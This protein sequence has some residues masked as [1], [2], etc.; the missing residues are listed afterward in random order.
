MYSGIKIPLIISLLLFKLSSISFGQTQE[1]FN[2]KM[3]EVYTA[4]DEKKALETAKELYK[5]V[6]GKKDLQNYTN[7]LMLKNIFENQAKDPELAEI[8]KEKSEKKLNELVSTNTN[9]NTPIGDDPLSQWNGIYYPALFATTDPNNASKALNFLS[10]N[11]SLQSFGN[12]TWVA[13][14][15]ERNGDFQKAK[16]NYEKALTLEKNAKEEYHPF[17]Y[18]SSFLAKSGEYLKAEEYIHKM[19]KLSEEAIEVL[20]N[21]Y[22]S[23]S[24]TTKLTYYQ[25]IGDFNSYF[26]AGEE[27][28]TLIKKMYNSSP[29][30]CDPFNMVRLVYAAYAKEMLREYKEAEKL[31]YQRDSAHYAVIECSNKTYP[32]YKQY[33][34]SFLPV[35]YLKVGKKSS[36]KNPIDYYIRET[37]TYYN[38]FSQYADFS[39]NY[40][41]GEHLAF[42]ASPKYHEIFKEVMD[43]INNT[44]DFREATKPFASYAYFTMRDSR[45]DQSSST[46]DQLF[47][48]N[49]DWINDVIFTF[50]EKAFVAYYNSKLK[51]GYDDYHSFVKIAKEKKSKLYPHLASQ[52]YNNLLFTK[53]ISLKGTQK[54]KQAFL[55]ANDPSIQN[56]Y[57]QWIEKKQDLIRQYQKSEDPI[58][59][60][61]GSN[62]DQIKK[63]QDEVNHLENELA[64]KAK[65]FKKYLK[66]PSPDWKTIQSQLKEGEAAV[67]MIRFQW[68]DQIYY[69]DTAYY[70][71]YIITKTSEYPSVVYMPTLASELDHRHYKS[72][73]N[74]IKY[75][76]KDKDSYKYYWEPI[77]EELKGIKKIYF[78]PDGIYHLINMSTLS[79]PATGQYILDEMDIHYTTSSIELPGEGNTNNIQ[80]AVLIGRPSYEVNST[81]TQVALSEDNTRS[82]VRAFRGNAIADLPG[83]EQEVLSIKSEMEKNGV[84]VSYYTKEHATEDKIYTL[85]S[86]DILHI[87]THGYWSQIGGKATDGYRSFNAMVNSGLLLTGVVNYYSAQ[88]FADTYDG[89]LTAYEAQ[90]LNL[91]NT[92][93]VILSAC[94]TS[95]GHFDAG[96]GVYGLQR[97]FRAA[98][99]KSIMTSLW[100]VDDEATKDFM[101]LFYQNYLK[102]KNKFDAFR[103]AQK[104]LKEKYPDPYY[105]GAFVLSGI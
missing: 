104:K 57:D 8:C 39:I 21:S 80:N 18:Y 19:E 32:N 15:F 1:D 14:A 13:Y 36:L 90:G 50:G 98:G 89:I 103:M 68:K 24:L 22:K 85:K 29:V 42:L 43:H 101:I 99:A 92:S 49:I 46:Y 56:L 51:Q 66:L 75:K 87:A 83:T 33:T 45:Y 23:E 62:K 34:L 65:D 76:I 93:L 61:D 82:F 54:R 81:K 25:A 67:E 9:S 102:S 48:L 12:Y 88:D 86:P 28:Y 3:M 10:K 7:Y 78:S 44:K 59:N 91:E 95:L 30:P 20:K 17:G 38:S 96:E 37:E 60:N 53:S 58:A 84:K 2:N 94:E 79:N 52:A 40:M 100:K 16:E 27:Q 26:Q 74:N 35:Y 77:K 11:P 31:W 6:E 73:Q 41:K 47:K 55:K 64:T 5:M 105:W 63:L 72:Y 70:A 4:G 69:S 97:A 71:A